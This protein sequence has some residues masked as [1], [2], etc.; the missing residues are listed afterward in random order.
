MRELATL[1]H[2]TDM[3]LSIAEPAWKAEKEAKSP[4][5]PGLLTPGAGA[6]LPAIGVVNRVS[7]VSTTNTASSFAGSVLLAFALTS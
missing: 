3:N 7:S 1:I 4:F 6:H 2:R 5:P